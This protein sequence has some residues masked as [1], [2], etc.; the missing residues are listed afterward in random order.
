VCLAGIHLA[1]LERGYTDPTDNE[2]LRLLIRGV[3]CLQ[4]DSP[5]RRLPITI[6]VL[7]TLKHQLCISHLPPLKQHLL[8]AAFT[9]AFYDFLCVS[10]FT[11]VA[12]QW[13]EIQFNDQHVSVMIRQ[14]KTDT[15]CKGHVLNL[16][17]T[18][19]STRNMYHCN[20]QL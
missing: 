6:A 16:T 3:Q 20:M 15:F 2:S 14:S 19:T 9:Q 11:G 7:H 17:P 5:R 4:G 8:L 10:E 1:Y 18:Q 13:S 12:L